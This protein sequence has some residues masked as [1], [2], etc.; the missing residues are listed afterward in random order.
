M[1]IKK[2]LLCLYIFNLPCFFASCGAVSQDNSSGASGEVSGLAD[3]AGVEANGGVVPPAPPVGLSAVVE[4][5][6]IRCVANTGI[7]KNLREKVVIFNE[8]MAL[9]DSFEKRKALG[10]IFKDVKNDDVKNDVVKFLCA[11]IIEN[12]LLDS[13]EIFLGDDDLYNYSKPLL[14]FEVVPWFASLPSYSDIFKAKFGKFDP[15]FANNIVLTF[16]NS[17]DLNDKYLDDL[18]NFFNEQVKGDFVTQDYVA[19]FLNETK[20]NLVDSISFLSSVVSV[21]PDGAVGGVDDGV[22]NLKSKGIP[23]YVDR[24]D[25]MYGF[26]ENDD[27]DLTRYRTNIFGNY[28]L[29][30]VRHNSYKQRLKRLDL[31]L[32]NLV[33]AKKNDAG[34]IEAYNKCRV[35]TFENMLNK[36]I[37]E[38]RLALERIEKITV[39]DILECLKDFSFDDKFKVF[40]PEY[41]D[42][43]GSYKDVSGKW[44]F[45]RERYVR[46]D[47]LYEVYSIFKLGFL[48]YSYAGN[49]FID[50]PINF[51]KALNLPVENLKN[52]L[53]E[54][55][56]RLD[57]LYKRIYGY[58]WCDELDK[59]CYL[60]GLEFFNSCGMNMLELCGD[61]PKIGPFRYYGRLLFV[62][63][64]SL[65]KEEEIYLRAII[66]GLEGMLPRG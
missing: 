6:D 30:D 43:T 48:D 34:F 44:D 5:S 18:K 36:D 14:D 64:L 41:G 10:L 51:I 16:S 58:I 12:V 11:R 7:D 61:E 40:G 32:F 45:D 60:R 57:Q 28:E 35:D 52:M 24:K 38:R 20:K 59:D 63:G 37:K 25:T 17:Q 49:F 19:N 31:K 3:V 29:G 4:K 53:E 66:E 47:Y 39:Q 55:R 46:L 23:E 50:D 26:V 42:S 33:E 21:V 13:Y 56:A 2:I 15:F 62:V 54:Y 27:M 22:Y 65:Y 8:A 1:K 9:F